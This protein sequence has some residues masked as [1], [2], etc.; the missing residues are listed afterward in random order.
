MMDGR[1]HFAIKTLA[2]VTLLTV[3]PSATPASAADFYAGKQIQMRIGAAA[4]GGYDFY[5]RLVAR[6]IGRHIPGNPTIV[7]SNMPGAGARKLASYMFSVAPKDGTEIG[8]VSPNAIVGPLIDSSLRNRY[9]PRKFQYIGTADTGVR[10]CITWGSSQAKTFADAQRRKTVVGATSLRGAPRDFAVFLNAVAG[11]KFE[12]ISGYKGTD[13]ILLAM[14]KGE[15]EGICGFEWVSLISQKPDWV[16]DKKINILV[17]MALD[18]SE[19]ISRLGVP[20]VWKY[21]KGEEDR[22]LFG[23]LVSE[24]QF[25]RPYLLP[26]GTPKDRVDILRAA[27]DAM[28]KD[29]A[30]LAVAKK[31]G[32]SLTPATGAAVQAMVEKFYATPAKLVERSEAIRAGGTK[33]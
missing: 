24:Q 33:K 5:G 25:Q 21:I 3:G 23:F 10:V 6:N 1:S 26:P 14:E 9:D 20:T 18:E 8:A 4:G 31:L 7:A 17:Q 22:R 2:T 30:F 12:I 29:S 19:E 13:E 16:R 15:V 27:F 11:A 28:V 32:V